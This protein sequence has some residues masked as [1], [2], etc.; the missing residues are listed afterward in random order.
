M[1]KNGQEIPNTTEYVVTI[2]DRE[3][4]Q[5]VDQEDHAAGHYFVKT[6]KNACI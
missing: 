3:I 1:T 4:A 6:G 2:F 5:V